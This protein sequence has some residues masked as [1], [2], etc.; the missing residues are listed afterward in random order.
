[1]MFVSKIFQS[2]ALKLFAENKAYIKP[3]T[4]R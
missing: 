1:M 3:R 4:E 2:E